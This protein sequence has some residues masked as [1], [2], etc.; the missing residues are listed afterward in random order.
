M[1]TQSHNY[2]L[3]TWYAA[4]WEH[5]LDNPDKLLARKICDVPLVFFKTADGN[6]AALDDRCCHRAAPLSMG[7]VETNCLR[8]MYHGILYDTSGKV[9][10]IPGQSNISKNMKVRSYPVCAKGGMIWIWMGDVALADRSHIHDF[11]PLTDKAN[12]RG[13]EKESYLHYQANWMLIVDNLA[14]FTHVAFVHTNTLGGSESY[15][16]ESV[17]DEV[18]PL[19]TGLAIKRW[20][21]NS[22]PPPFHKRVIPET[23]H[24]AKLDRLNDIEM[25]LPGI[26]LMKT[27]F[28]PVADPS[29]TSSGEDVSRREYRNCQYMTPETWNS[30]HFFWNYLHNFDLDNKATTQSLEQSLLE[31]FM[32]DKVFIE[33]QQALL[34]KSPD[35]VPRGISGD[36]ALTVFRSKWNERLRQEQA[37]ANESD[38]DQ[39]QPVNVR[40]LI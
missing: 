20:H 23:E 37:R 25:H 32:E 36:K 34:E 14:D 39:E 5:E 31:G 15:A 6:Y 24:T 21:K 10:E 26:F 8:C 12:W 22:P 40:A 7:R 18:L 38:E 2:V 16:Y 4:A 19:Q 29:T 28:D 13:F 30:T 33:Q 3:D 9:V 35:F 11:P 27:S 1:S 17:P